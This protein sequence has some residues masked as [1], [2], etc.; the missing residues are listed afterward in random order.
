MK[1]GIE[2][3]N[4]LTIVFCLNFKKSA[5]ISLAVLKAVSPEVIGAAITPNIANNPPNFPN[6]VTEIS[7]TRGAALLLPR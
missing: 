7:F 3:I 2:I 6:Q 1:I 5:V 4:L